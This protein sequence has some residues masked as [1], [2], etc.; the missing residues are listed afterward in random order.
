[1]RRVLFISA[2]EGFP[3]GGSEPL[4]TQAASRLMA[5]GST[6]MASVRSW[7]NPA[8]ELMALRRQGCHLRFRH[9]TLWNRVI[10]RTFPQRR[11]GFVH[12]FKPD[13]IVVS[14]GVHSEGISWLSLCR[15]SGFPYAVVVQCATEDLWPADTELDELASSLRAARRCYFVS[16]GNL[17]TVNLQLGAPL[18]NA[19]VIRNPHNVAREAKPAW[20]EIDGVFKLACVA[21]LEP[22]AKGQ[23]ILFEVL[24]LQKWRERP[25]RVSLF[26]EG[27]NRR[28]LELLAKEYALDQV[29][30]AGFEPDVSK[31]WSS[32]HALVLPSRYEGLPL[33]LVEAMLCRRFCIV[34]DVAGNAELIKDGTDGFVAAAPTVGLL[35]D[36]MERAWASRDRWEEIGRA[37]AASIRQQIP[38]DPVGEFV[39]DLKSLL[40]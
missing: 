34:T 19:R 22:K 27:P 13:L 38:A 6:V 2:M 5:A 36:A 3:W 1:M 31:I 26:G 40:R 10:D 29:R 9:Q 37:A 32:H 4:W 35:D 17:K 20:P 8:P 12:R 14:Q 15:D 33:T 30:F 7:P 21:R 23:D 24:R 18:N 16:G 28:H 25:L 11:F 39:Q